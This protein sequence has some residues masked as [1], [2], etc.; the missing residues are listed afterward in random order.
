MY[1]E[2]F[3]NNVFMGLRLSHD[4]SADIGRKFNRWTV[5]GTGFLSDCK[6]HRA[7]IVRC[8]C[9]AT[10]KV[11]KHSLFGG[12][13]GGCMKCRTLYGN[14]NPKWR[15]Y[16]AVPQ[17]TYSIMCRSA[18]ARGLA[19]GVSIEDLQEQYEKQA[20]KCA[21]TGIPIRIGSGKTGREASVDR[22]DSSKGYIK[23]NIQWV[24]KDV[25]RMKNK[26]DEGYFLRMCKAVVEHKGA[27]CQTH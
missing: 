20:G 23:D 5:I 2:P 13:S 18:K 6:K 25:N 15:G 1:A 11:N 26:F 21:L 12:K 7:Y 3:A 24:H 9:G 16:G 14:H 8:L 27:D 4:D 10:A 17:N 19:V 22:I